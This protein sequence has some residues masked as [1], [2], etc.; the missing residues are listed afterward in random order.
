[1]RIDRKIEHFVK[2]EGRRPR[3]LVSSMGEKGNAKAYDHDTKFLATIFAETG[4][5][6]DISPR[7]Q[8]PQAIARMAIEND[9]HVICL[10]S[11]ANSHKILIAD[12]VKMLDAE[13]ADN[14]KIVIGG[15]IPRSDYKFLYDVGV[16][17]ILRSVPADPAT[18]NQ[19][20]DLFE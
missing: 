20:L 11:N 10:F 1:M 2:R 4:F 7:R 16:D 15:S 19:L 18:I 3:I 9:V 8:T 14:I 6:V 17:M 12:L 13:H 5:D